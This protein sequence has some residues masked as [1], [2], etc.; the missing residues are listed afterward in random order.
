MIANSASGTVSIEFGL[1]G[2]N[3]A[4]STAC[5]T[6]AHAIA[7][8]YHAIKWDLAD[9]MVTGGAEAA[10]TVMGLGGFCS[11]RALSDRNDNPQIASRPFDKDR[12]GF[13]LS[14]GAGIL[15]LEE[16]E[17][18]KKR[19]ADIFCEIFGIGNTAD[20]YHITAPH[21]QGI[22][23]AKAMEHARCTWPSGTPRM[24]NIS[25]LTE[26]APNSATQQRQGQSRK[27]LVRT[28]TNW[29]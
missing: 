8:A 5:A 15:V 6:S 28:L 22:G 2:P 16:L 24:S 27:C 11:A 13:V 10:I 17:K 29:Q 25:T 18:A 9:M 23:A 21:E 26:P 20:A 14:E 19:G 12:D 3:T 4:V 1:Q 7:D